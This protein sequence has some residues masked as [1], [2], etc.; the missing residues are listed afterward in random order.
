LSKHSSV[1]V[2]DWKY[3]AENIRHI[4]QSDSW[5]CA[6]MSWVVFQVAPRRSESSTQPAFTDSQGCCR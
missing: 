2:S 4:W 3:V 6:K 1:I 5:Q